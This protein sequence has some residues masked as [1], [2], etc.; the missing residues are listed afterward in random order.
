MTRSGSS[1]DRASGY[2]PESWGFESLLEHKSIAESFSM[3]DNADVTQLVEFLPSKQDVASSS[4]V[5]RSKVDISSLDVIHLYIGV[6]QLV[7]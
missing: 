1:T 5:I 7:E 4:L 6:A 3:L 2:E